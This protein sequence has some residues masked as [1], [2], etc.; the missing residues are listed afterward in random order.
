[1]FQCVVMYRLVCVVQIACCDSHSAAVSTT[2]K[3]YTFGSKAGGKLGQ[4][5]LDSIDG[6]VAEVTKFL[7]AN[8]QHEIPGVKIGYV[9]IS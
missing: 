3:L 2:G 6:K 8:E 9:S 5:K 4:G 1:M 7:L